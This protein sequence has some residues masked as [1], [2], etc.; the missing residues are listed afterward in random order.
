MCILDVPPAVEQILAQPARTEKTAIG[1]D[2]WETSD[3]R[4]WLAGQDIFL[5]APCVFELKLAEI[6]FYLAKLQGFEVV[7]CPAKVP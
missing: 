6:P 3:L 4:H 1:R 2:Q 5:E 7:G